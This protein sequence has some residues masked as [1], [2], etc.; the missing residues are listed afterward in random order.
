MYHMWAAQRQFQIFARENCH[1]RQP[2]RLQTGLFAGD[3]GPAE[4]LA[5]LATPIL[6]AVL[7]LDHAG[8][9]AD[10]KSVV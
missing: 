2:S 9:L 4:R 7:R 10:R 6:G 1:D 3:F 8:A 5:D